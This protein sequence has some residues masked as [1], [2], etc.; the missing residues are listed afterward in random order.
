MA[1]LGLLAGLQGYEQVAEGPA[2]RL[3]EGITGGVDEALRAYGTVSRV[4]QGDEEGQR[5]QQRLDMTEALQPGQLRG[6]ELLNDSRSMALKESGDKLTRQNDARIFGATIAE[7]MKKKPDEGGYADPKDFQLDLVN[8]AMKLG[9]LTHVKD[10]VRD[11]KLLLD[12]SETS[13]QLGG[14]LGVYQDTIRDAAT[15]K[16]P[17]ERTRMSLDGIAKI[18]ADFPIGASHPMMKDLNKHM[19][20]DVKQNQPESVYLAIEKYTQLRVANPSLSA[21]QA[22][23]RAQ[24]G[25]HPGFLPKMNTLKPQDVKDDEKVRQAGA[26]ETAKK[27]SE[28]PFELEKIRARGEQLQIT[29]ETVP[30]KA[31]GS[32]KAQEARTAKET[33]QTDSLAQLAAFEDGQGPELNQTQVNALR[34]NAG[35]AQVAD[36]AMDTEFKKMLANRAMALKPKSTGPS[37]FDRALSSLGM[38]PSLQQSRDQAVT[39]LFPKKTWKELTPAEKESVASTINK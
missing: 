11:Y 19:L 2:K 4:R 39:R 10:A 25:L 30:G 38:G 27:K 15:A 24:E 21:G 32:D 20:E 36:S 9:D 33:L 1:R 12:N 34:K 6:Q 35:V 22:W 17:E 31:P 37:L 5:S 7:R 28:Q 29:K 8:M 13:K 3:A 16:S 26:I 18:Y 23:S 14:A